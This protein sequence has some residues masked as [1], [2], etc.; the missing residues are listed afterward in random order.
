MI[1]RI[2][3]FAACS[4]IGSFAIAHSGR[5]DSSGGHNSKYGYHYHNGGFS[6][7]SP[8]ITYR[9][10][11]ISRTATRTNYRSK[12]RK[13][14]PGKK[15]KHRTTARTAPRRIVH[16]INFEYKLVFHDNCH[17][18]MLY[19]KTLVDRP[20]LEA[21]ARRE[22]KK[23]IDY[24]LPGMQATSQPWAITRKLSDGRYNCSIK[25]QNLVSEETFKIIGKVAGV[26]SGNQFALVFDELT[27]SVKLWGVLSPKKSSFAK[28]AKNYLSDLVDGKTVTVYCRKQTNDKEL[29]GIVRTD[30]GENVNESVLNAGYGRVNW[31]LG[32]KKLESLESTARSKKIGLWG[33]GW[34]PPS[35][36]H[37]LAEI[38]NLI[39][40]Y[41]AKNNVNPLSYRK[42]KQTV[43]RNVSGTLRR[44][45][46]KRD[47]DQ[48]LICGSD[49]TL[50]VDHKRA[51]FNGGDNSEKNLGTL[52]DSCRQKKSDLDWAIQRRRQKSSSQ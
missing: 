39:D 42:G 17:K 28:S 27:F 10:P 37:T 21:V 16:T 35:P 15:V 43:E 44:K 45:V 29:L 19:I 11:P 1:T 2:L 31:R 13:P 8:R 47:N 38:G 49:E 50:V 9:P 33:D 25:K 5:T 40:E 7:P 52:C 12:Y 3:T 20:T 24:Y 51:L 36:K 48:C 32:N 14:K 22:Q 6:K 30:D 46:F 18:V 34:R 4:F 41:F 26:Q 23:R